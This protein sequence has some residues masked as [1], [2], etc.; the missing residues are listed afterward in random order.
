MIEMAVLVFGIVFFL[1][2]LMVDLA[3]IQPFHLLAFLHVPQLVVWGMFLIFFAWL[4]GDE[5]APWP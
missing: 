2:V 4:F 5:S 3:I 1:S